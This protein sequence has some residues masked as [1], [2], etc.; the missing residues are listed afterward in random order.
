MKAMM[1]SQIAQ[2]VGGSLSGE[3]I[4]VTAGPSLKS[5]D[6]EQG[7]IFLAIRGENADGHDFAQDAFSHGA[8]LAITTRAVSQRHILVD[9]VTLALTSLARFVRSELKDLK[10]I[11]ITGS[12][13][14][15]TT[16]DLLRHMLSQHG[17]TVAPSGNYN[18]ELGVPLT[19]L[20]CSPE[21]K[22]AVIEMG[23][24]H[25]GDIAHL[26]SIARPDIAVVLRVGMAHLG[27]FGSIETIA[28]TKSELISSLSDSGIAI[29]GQYDPYTKAMQSL[30]AGRTITFGNGPSDEVRA[31]EIEM[32]EGCPHFDLVTP[33]GRASVGLR[34]VGEHQISNAL[35]CAAVGTALGLSI[36]S[37]ATALS[38]A[39]IESKWRMEIREF[40]EVLLINDSYNASP[41]AV[42]A[43]L[44][45]LILF[46]QE[47]GGRAWA[48]L[49]KMAELGESSA[50]AHQQVGTLAYRMGI[51]HLVCVDAPDYQPVQRSE[52]QTNLHLCDRN[53]ARALA[54]QIEPGDVILVKA[55]RSERFEILAEE[56]EEVVKANILSG[57]VGGGEE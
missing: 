23:A 5:S 47:R 38:T 1:A 37:I 53:G 18:N 51:D 6:I 46:A 50:A 49:G 44:R 31:T 45:T 7:G 30:H 54:E 29:L 10:V 19:L 21:T 11:G 4:L 15:T 32:R 56:I 39:L 43:A 28:K 41:D 16:K 26:A 8:L 27:E 42:E 20:A 14:K 24:R 13:G 40:S 33:D 57:E 25:S 2:V 36:E 52:G 55:S 9:D 3:D 12:Q 17:Q 22:Y 34:I 48:F 35:A